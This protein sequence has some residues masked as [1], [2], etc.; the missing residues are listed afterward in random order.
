MVEA[1]STPRL[2]TPRSFEEVRD[3]LGQLYTFFERSGSVQGRN[4]V[5]IPTG[6]LYSFTEEHARDPSMLNTARYR[7]M[8]RNL[9]AANN[10]GGLHSGSFRGVEQIDLRNVGLATAT[11][12]SSMHCSFEVAPQDLARAYGILNRVI[13]PL[14][15]LTGNSTYFDGKLGW[16]INRLRLLDIAFGG[17]PGKWAPFASQDLKDGYGAYSRWIQSYLQSGR[18]LFVYP[19]SSQQAGSAFQ[20]ETLGFYNGTIWEWV[21]PRD[22][23]RPGALLPYRGSHLL[24]PTRCP[25]QLSSSGRTHRATQAALG[26]RYGFDHYGQKR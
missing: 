21:R 9:A 26:D 3:D 23:V 22:R 5:P 10:D 13:A 16:S 24:Y 12:T 2:I 15:A 6:T 25:T 17:A 8:E 11:A 1:K 14:M 20:R 4:A 19:E 18:P 7:E